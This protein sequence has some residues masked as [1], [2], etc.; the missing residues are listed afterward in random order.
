MLY[1]RGKKRSYVSV[2]AVCC[3]QTKCKRLS[4]HS[5]LGSLKI[6]CFNRF[7][8]FFPFNIHN[9]DMYIYLFVEWCKHKSPS[10][11]KKP[12]KGGKTIYCARKKYINISKK[13]RRKTCRAIRVVKYHQNMI[14][15]LVPW[16][17][18]AKTLFQNMFPCF[19]FQKVLTLTI[20]WFVFNKKRSKF[21]WL[22]LI[23]LLFFLPI[24]WHLNEFK[25]YQTDF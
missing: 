21:G 17:P 18:Y 3:Q 9:E 5:L 4:F 23:I 1:V 16:L 13:R 2:S 22:W 12:L 14:C 20:L 6:G 10:P 15:Y 24:K 25:K 8:S 7:P 11:R 19:I